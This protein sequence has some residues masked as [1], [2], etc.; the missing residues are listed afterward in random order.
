MEEAIKVDLKAV[1][2]SYT[3]CAII[4]PAGTSCQDNSYYSSW[5]S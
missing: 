1:G 4:A 2:C 5:E 3:I